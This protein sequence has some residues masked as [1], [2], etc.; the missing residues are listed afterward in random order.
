MDLQHLKN[1]HVVVNK[2]GKIIFA[3]AASRG[4]FLQSL[5]S[6]LTFS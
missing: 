4:S 6:Q 2:L 1:T 3:G 5:K